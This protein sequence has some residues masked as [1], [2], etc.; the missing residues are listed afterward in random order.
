MSIPVFVSRISFISMSLTKSWM[1]ESFFYGTVAAVYDCRTVAASLRAPSVDFHSAVIDRR[2][3][4]PVSCRVSISIQPCICSK[5]CRLRQPS[6]HSP[7]LLVAVLHPM[8]LLSMILPIIEKNRFGSHRQQ[9]QQNSQFTQKQHAVFPF[10]IEFRT[11]K[12][13]KSLR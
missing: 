6:W 3:N 12:P 11:R 10:G 4:G 13:R 7:R 8:I 2:Y 9:L 5:I 1:T